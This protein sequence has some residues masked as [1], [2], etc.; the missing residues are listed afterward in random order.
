MFYRAARQH[1]RVEGAR[2]RGA[3]AGERSL[4]TLRLA[5]KPRRRAPEGSAAPARVCRARTSSYILAPPQVPGHERHSRLPHAGRAAR[6]RASRPTGG[7]PPAPAA[8]LAAPA[9]EAPAQDMDLDEQP[10]AAGI[11]YPRSA[12][13]A[14]ADDSVRSP[15]AV[16]VERLIDDEARPS[17]AR[18]AARSATSASRPR[19]PKATRSGAVPVL[20]SSTSSA[21]ASC[22]A[23]TCRSRGANS[24]RTTAGAPGALRAAPP[25]IPNAEV[26]LVDQYAEA[27][28]RL[29]KSTGRGAEE[30]RPRGGRGTA[31]RRSRTITSPTTSTMRTATSRRVSRRHA[32]AGH[33]QLRRRG[34]R[35]R[36]SRARGSR[37]PRALVRRS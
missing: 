3:R 8:E 29:R 26:K 28:T 4:A 14:S 27:V 36:G 16:V 31:T 37:A 2:I 1:E 9:V 6:A 21:C 12:T 19:S 24:T 22:S 13:T 23:G 5:A 34:R 20:G 32:R 17:R 25:I 18:T 10:C 15:D 33:H 7:R 11:D 35:P 30:E